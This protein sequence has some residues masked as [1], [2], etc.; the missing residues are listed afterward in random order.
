VQESFDKL[1]ECRRQSDSHAPRIRTGRRLSR[2]RC[3]ISRGSELRD[4][5]LPRL[6][7]GQ[8]TAG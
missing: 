7:N 6:K 4:W 3:L 5:L 2:T 1:G 8:L